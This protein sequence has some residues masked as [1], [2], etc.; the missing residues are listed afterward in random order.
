M[1]TTFQRQP[2][3]EEIKMRRQRPILKSTIYAMTL[4]AALW[5][6]VAQAMQTHPPALPKEASVEDTPSAEDTGATQAKLMKLLRVTPTLGQVL[7]S[8]PS[9]LSS[10]EYVGRTNPELAQFL[11]QHPEVGRNPG[12]YLF[13]DL[14]QNGQK[15]YEVLRPK[16]GFEEPR[17]ERTETE[18]VMNDGSPIVALICCGV[19]LVW[20]VRTLLENRRWGRVFRMQN[21][22]HAKLIDKF[23]SNQE[24]LGFMQT[25]AGK[26]FLEVAPIATDAD[27]RRVPNVVS[28]V[29]TTLQ[30]GV[31]MMLLGIGLLVVRHIVADGQTE[32][33]V[34]GVI[35]LMPGI[36]F[37]ISAGVT[38]A[39][40]GRLGLIPGSHAD[41]S[42]QIER[43]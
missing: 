4:T 17:R 22:M 23:G 2:P 10:Q 15:S 21:E 30:A 40:A 39:L 37:T 14:H 24:L 33:L 3:D 27:Q 38:W 31:V 5:A 35:V 43:Q 11:Q 13:S 18:I 26:R 7:A 1:H 20:L 9:L 32:L 12:F 29:L 16:Q 8:D 28:R 34:V 41:A 36:G 19:V 6:G 25:D 42:A